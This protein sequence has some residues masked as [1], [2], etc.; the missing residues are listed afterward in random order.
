MKIFN[1]K[2]KIDNKDLKNMR[3]MFVKHDNNFDGH[4]DLDEFKS[5]MKAV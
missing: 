3:E 2:I 5:I 4:L 1:I